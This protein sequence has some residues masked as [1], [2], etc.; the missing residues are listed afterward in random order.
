LASQP[1]DTEKEQ[2]GEIVKALDLGKKRKGRGGP[3]SY[4]KGINGNK[5]FERGSGRDAL[6]FFNGTGGNNV[7]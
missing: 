1:P 5:L 7:E 6:D 3:S 2:T 4:E